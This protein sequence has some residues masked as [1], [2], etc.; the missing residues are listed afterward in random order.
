MHANRSGSINSPAA[1]VNVNSNHVN[2]P[3]AEIES[4]NSTQTPHLLL[5][6]I[7][8]NNKYELGQSKK[9]V[10]TSI[11]R[12]PLQSSGGNDGIHLEYEVQQSWERS[13]NSAVGP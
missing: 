13:N 9:T 8:L 5:S 12:G 11:G 2:G 10:T 7:A 4:S 3:Y 6:S 1:K